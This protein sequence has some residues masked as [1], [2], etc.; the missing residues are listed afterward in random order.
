LFN[1]SC[2]PLHSLPMHACVRSD[3][4]AVAVAAWE[5]SHG[6]KVWPPAAYPGPTFCS[7]EASRR[8]H[9]RAR[10]GKNQISKFHSDLDIRAPV[11]VVEQAWC[12]DV[13][14]HLVSS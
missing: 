5:K 4:D 12:R 9:G 3:S 6:W 14:M 2:R 10:G 1:K 7:T 11:S 8:R 13:K